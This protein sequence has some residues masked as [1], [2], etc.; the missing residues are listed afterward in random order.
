MNSLID[1]RGKKIID[2]EDTLDKLVHAGAIVLIL[3]GWDAKYGTQDYYESHPIITEALAKFLADRKIKMLCL[4]TP[5]P[6]QEPY[7][8][9]KL[10]LAK[11]IP[12]A[13]NLKDLSHLDGLAFKIAAFPL[14]IEAEA[15]LARIVAITK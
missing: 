1:G 6:D 9:H 4:D 12:I 8:I 2:Y 5:S 15:S 7:P 11:S 3:T 10:L 13:E 14:N